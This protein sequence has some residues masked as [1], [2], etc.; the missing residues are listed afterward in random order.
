MIFIVGSSRSGTTMTARLLGLNPSVLALNEL[1]F[2]EQQWQP[3]D[4]GRKLGLAEARETLLLLFS[5]QRDG[6]YRRHLNPSYEPEVDA[7]LARHQVGDAT[8][9]KHQ[10]LPMFADAE[11][12]RSGKSLWCEQT[13]RNVYYLDVIRDLFPEAKIV[14]LV[15][16]PRDVLLSQKNR[17]RRRFRGGNM[18]WKETI[19]QWLNYHPITILKL[20]IGAMRRAQ[21]E[22]GR[23][24]FF[25]Q[26]YEDLVAQPARSVSSLCAFLG[27]EYAPSMLAVPKIGSSLRSD[28]PADLGIDASKVG[29]WRRGGLSQA[30]LYLCERLAGPLMS[31]FDYVSDGV[32]LTPSVFGHYFS[33]PIKLGLAIP[34]SLDRIGSLG[35]AIRRRL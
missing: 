27:L 17:W 19:R 10:L 4:K 6:Y 2:F 14:Q 1:H 3:S 8:H 12:A 33:F 20:W 35:D 23:A 13:P 24:G 34:F 18:P 16:D 7:L 21:N 5:S 28:K 26:R 9:E 31:Q 32:R 29:G 25:V 22:S 15:R 11:A 30:E